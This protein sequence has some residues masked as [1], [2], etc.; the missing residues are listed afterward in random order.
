[1]PPT[2]TRQQTPRDDGLRSYLMCWALQGLC[3]TV[4]ACTATV[5]LAVLPWALRYACTTFVSTIVVP[6]TFPSI[7]SHTYNP[8]LRDLCNLFHATVW[9]IHNNYR[10][11]SASTTVV[12]NRQPTL[13]QGFH[14]PTLAPAFQIQARHRN[15]KGLPHNPLNYI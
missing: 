3:T 13:P 7:P 14:S 1:M 2:S 15:D 10:S 6:S 9:L 11:T 4:C 5:L 8:P 12:P